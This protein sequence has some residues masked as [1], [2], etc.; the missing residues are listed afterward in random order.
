MAVM[1]Y[2][3]SYAKDTWGRSSCQPATATGAVMGK[4]LVTGAS[5][6]V[7]RAIRPHLRTRYALRLF[8]RVAPE[9]HPTEEV[10]VG[11]L[12]RRNDVR[13]SLEGVSGVV[14]LACVHGLEID[15]EAT[16]DAN[17]RAQ[18]VLLEEMARLRIRRFVYASSHHVL[19]LHPREGFG[20]DGAQ[21][22][23]DAYY[24]LSK[25]FGEAACS[26]F[27]RRHDLATLVIRIGNA[28]PTVRDDR[29]LSI[30]VSAGDLASLVTIGLESDEISYD[31]VYGTSLCPQPLFENGRARELGY[32]PLDRAED[33][34][35]PEFVPYE[36][37]PAEAGR[38]SVGGAYAAS[39]LPRTGPPQSLPPQS[40]TGPTQ[41]PRSGSPRPEP[42]HS[43]QSHSGQRPSKTPPPE[44]E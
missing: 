12:A 20:G 33:H 18:L 30:W 29:A 10:V 8:D 16:L 42:Q 21:L 6:R 24:G 19:G 38:D 9:A 37:M 31:V 32:R 35:D 22:A 36:R 40:G 23:P 43:E 44:Q 3:Q 13:A 15:F 27:S 7:G 5:G 2:D 41:P 26:M 14:H 34:L 11:D 1:W 39:E 4:I 17:Y 28:D 25:A